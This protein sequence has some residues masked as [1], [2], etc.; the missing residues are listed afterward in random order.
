MQVSNDLV[1]WN[2]ADDISIG[3]GP[4]GTGPNSVT[5]T[6][7]ENGGAPDTIIVT[8]PKGA[9]TKKFARVVATQ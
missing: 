8:I 4:N 1:T 6:V 3:A 5:Y 7:A 2:P 9:A